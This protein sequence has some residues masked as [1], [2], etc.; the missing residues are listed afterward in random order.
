MKNKEP[1]SAPVRPAGGR[2]RQ[3][4]QAGRNYEKNVKINERRKYEQKDMF[5]S[6]FNYPA[7][8]AI[9]GKQ[10]FDRRRCYSH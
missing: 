10:H 1:A 3:V 9:I 8:I 7:R 6:K 5:I 4:Q 2:R